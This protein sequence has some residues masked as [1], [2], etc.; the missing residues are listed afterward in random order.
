M[1][2]CSRCKFCEKIPDVAKYEFK[3]DGN[4]KI[5]TYKKIS[6]SLTIDGEY[7]IFIFFCPICGRKLEEE[8]ELP[9]VKVGMEDDCK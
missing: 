3:N 7:G 2:D 1:R 6:F 4:F 9:R 5:A 8:K